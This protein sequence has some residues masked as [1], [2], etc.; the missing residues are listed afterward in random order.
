MI[1]KCNRNVSG[2]GLTNNRLYPVIAYKIDTI[3]NNITYQ[4]VDDCGS[5]SWIQADRFDLISLSKEEYIKVVN[6]NN[7]K[8]VYKYLLDSDFFTDYYLENEKSVA[9][10][11]KLEDT[12]VSILASELEV[13]KVLKYLEL[14]GYEDESADI[15]I[16]AFFLK[17]RQE[18]II[19][20]SNDLYEQI[21]TFSNYI[22]QVIVCNL[23]HYKVTEVE[24]LFMQLY[25]NGLPYN[26]EILK[27]V[28][29]YLNV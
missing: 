19:K 8:Y 17:A 11:K 25:L 1:L 5:L 6:D 24:S 4:I 16:K 3:D 20:Y 2:E 18:D 7:S 14:V 23:S 28:N 10:N 22:V 21:S 13:D 27:I 9:A 12:L 15:L 29:D 26:N